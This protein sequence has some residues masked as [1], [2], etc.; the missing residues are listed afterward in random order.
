MVATG[1]ACLVCGATS[2]LDAAFACPR[3]GGNQEVRYDLAALR[4]TWTPPQ[5]FETGRHDVWRYAPLLP[6][7]GLAHVPPVRVG[8]T[9]LYPTPRLA[10]HAGLRHVW[11]KDDGLNPS[12][13]FKDRASAIVA[14][15]AAAAGVPVVAGASTGNAGSSMAC[16]AASLGL[17]AVVFVPKAAPPAK[18][19]QL[20]TFGAHVIAVDGTYDD[21]FALCTEVCAERGWLNRNTGANP[22][23]RE[24]KK[25]CALEIAEQLG[26]RAPDRVFVSVGD[27]NILTGLWKGFRDL[28]EAGF[29][30]RVPR[31]MAVQSERSNAIA[32][33]VRALRAAGVTRDTLDPTAIAIEPV[34]A[35]TIA[36][37][38]SV[39]TPADGVAAVRAIFESDGD[40]IE[41]SDEA[42]LAAIPLTARLTGVFGEPAGVTSVAGL[43]ASAA[44]GDVAPDE[45]VVCVNTGSG[46]KD[47]AAARKVAGEPTVIEPTRAA[48]DAVWR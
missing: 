41:V 38:I 5:G 3:C 21:A 4:K 33:A 11:L 48:F 8:F 22:F 45:R 13:S 35:T 1:L 47:I 16:M 37:S 32:R 24:G 42:I 44:R 29:L 39:D 17:T 25:T 27:G 46:L 43:L 31:L 30:D 34:R 36:D 26:W 23:T 15:R 19:A 40:V 28:V 9:P 20:L 2:D 10:A 6:V 7:R 18:I 12:A 14:A